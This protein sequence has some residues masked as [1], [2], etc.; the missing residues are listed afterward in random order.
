MYDNKT[1][2][3]AMRLQI[4]V[5]KSYYLLKEK[6]KKVLKALKMMIFFLFFS[7]FLMQ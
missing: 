1:I 4:K 5:I 7:F 6:V 3:A 2:V